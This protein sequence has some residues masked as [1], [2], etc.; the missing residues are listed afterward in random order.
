MPFASLREMLI[1]GVSPTKRLSGVKV[2]L[3]SASTSNL[4]TLAISFTLVP[5]SK[6]G[7]L[8]AGKPT[9]GSPALKV[10]RPFWTWPCGPSVWSPVPVGVTAVTVAR[11]LALATVPFTSARLSSTSGVLPTNVLTGVKVT[12]PSPSTSNLPTLAISFTF[13][14]VSK[15]G[16][17]FS[18]KPTCELP[19]SKVTFPFWTWPCGP[20]VWA[21]VALGVTF[22]T[23]G[24][25]LAVTGVPFL[26]TRLTR[27]G[28]GVPTNCLSGV[29]VTDPSG[30]TSKIPTFGTT[31]RLLPSSK[32]AGVSLSSGTSGLPLTKFG[33]PV[34]GRP[35]LPALVMFVPVGVTAVTV[36]L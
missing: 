17:L 13:V 2:T 22:S 30:A 23:V 12:L 1:S 19:G 26:S 36:A 27:T 11:Y 3:P 28:S 21:P 31:L 33:L 14:P 24:V 8:L 20:F 6:T 4:P 18:G 7:V 32:V 5:V 25:Y 34:C 35:C 29:K 16:V 15:T 10:T 9:F